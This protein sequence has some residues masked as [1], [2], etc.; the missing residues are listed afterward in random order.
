L[1]TLER[2]NR[3][4]IRNSKKIGKANSAQGSPLSQPACTPSLPDRRAP[5]VGATPS[6]HS[7]SLSRCQVG[8]TCRRQFPSLVRSLS[9]SVSRARS[10]VPSHCPRVS[11][12]LSLRRGPSL[13]DPPSSRTP[14]TI[15]CALAHVA[16]FLGHNACPRAQLPFRAPPVPRTHPSPHFARLHP[17]S[18]SAHA[19][20]RR[21]RPAPVFPAIQ[22]A[23][24]RSKPPRASPRGE[25]LV[26]VP[27]FPYCVLCSSNFAFAGA[28][29]RRSA[30]LARWPAD[31]AWS[32]S[33]E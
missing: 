26:P 8:P 33:S 7:P 18:R 29:P 17:L 2:I 6:A 31:S 21:R 9:L 4:G 3:K 13:L 19:A 15:V 24:D 32:S 14:W 11:P 5:P 27:N 1:K 30:V 16:G 12:F 23:G 22:L 20:S 28:W 10:P 25:T